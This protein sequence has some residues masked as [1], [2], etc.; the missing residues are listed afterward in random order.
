MMSRVE[1]LFN[2]VDNGFKQVVS[3]DS[4]KSAEENSDNDEHEL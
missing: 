1:S 2:V 3:C 4:C